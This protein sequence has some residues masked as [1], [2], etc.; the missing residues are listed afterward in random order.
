MDVILGK[1]LP[2]VKNDDP[3][4]AIERIL[5]KAGGNLK[6]NANKRKRRSEQKLSDHDANE[7]SI[8]LKKQYW[9]MIQ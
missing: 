1:R 2:F 5:M 8:Q 6:E 3:V 9:K 4:Y 7:I